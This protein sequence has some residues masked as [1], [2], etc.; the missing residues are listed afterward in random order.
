MYQ[1]RNYLTVQSNF[2][3]LRFVDRG[4]E[5]TYRSPPPPI[6]PRD[7]KRIHIDVGGRTVLRIKIFTHTNQYTLN[8]TDDEKVGKTVG[9][10]AK[11]GIWGAPFC[12]HWTTGGGDEER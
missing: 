11:V 5:S 9:V 12:A 4:D 6:D 10:G 2:A 7:L 1:L 3:N 8:S